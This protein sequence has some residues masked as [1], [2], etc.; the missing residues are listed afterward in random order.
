V[1]AVRSPRWII[2]GQV[3]VTGLVLVSLPNTL[4]NLVDIAGR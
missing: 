3:L 2:G 1:N 4:S